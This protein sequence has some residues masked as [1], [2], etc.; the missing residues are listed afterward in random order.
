MEF[1][2]DRVWKGQAGET[3]SLGTAQYGASC[4]FTFVEGEKY[5]VYSHDGATVSLCSRTKLIANAREDLDALGEG[6]LPNGEASNPQDDAPSSG[7]CGM[8][9]VISSASPDLA[10]LGLAAGLMWAG[11]RKRPH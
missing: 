7:A 1:E 9:P 11:L 5:L 2:V 3:M 10:M 6:N 4:G 8:A